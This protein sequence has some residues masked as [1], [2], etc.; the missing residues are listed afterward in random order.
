M[1]NPQPAKLVPDGYEVRTEDGSTWFETEG[2]F[3]LGVSEYGFL[4]IGD[5]IAIDQETMRRL[6]PALAFFAEQGRLPTREDEPTS[7]ESMMVESW[8]RMISEA[9][10]LEAFLAKPT[11]GAEGWEAFLNYETYSYTQAERDYVRYCL[12]KR[13]REMRGVEDEAAERIIAERLREAL[14][15]LDAQGGEGER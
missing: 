15:Q 10:A 12:A 8:R 7:I 3:V 9:G 1:T 6:L 5:E 11:P 14:G 2:F 13:I 4:E